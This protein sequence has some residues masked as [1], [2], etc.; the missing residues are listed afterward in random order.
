MNF[1]SLSKKK[2]LRMTTN[3]LNTMQR[4]DIFY[5]YTNNYRSSLKLGKSQVL[6]VQILKSDKLLKHS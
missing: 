4:I 5:T 3:F 6:I 2:S 1:L